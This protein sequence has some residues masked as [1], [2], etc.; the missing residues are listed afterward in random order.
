MQAPLD[1]TRYGRILTVGALVA[2]VVC[3]GV[4]LRLSGSQF[5]QE[6][7]WFPS[8]SDGGAPIAGVGFE[9]A[10][11]T[12][13]TGDGRISAM[14]QRGAYAAGQEVTLTAVAAPGSAFLG[15]AGDLDGVENPITL[16]V[17][18]D[19]EVSATFVADTT[20][21]AISGT[22][23]TP[24][25]T[26]ALIRWTTDDPASS[27]VAVGTTEAHE[28]GTFG[29]SNLTR[30][31]SVT[32]RDLAPGTTYRFAVSSTNGVDMSRRAPEGLFATPASG[33]PA[34]DVFSGP[35][36]VVGA[37]GE[38]QTWVNV[39]GNVGDP[40]GV[41][42]L[43]YSLNGGP[44][45]PLTVGPDQRRLQNPGDFN[46]EI[47]YSDLHPGHNQ[48]VVTATDSGGRVTTSTVDVDRRDGGGP[49]PRYRTDWAGA[50]RIG[51]RAQVVDGRW[52]LDGDTVRPLEP[53]YDRVLAVGDLSWHDY[54]VTVPV[55]VNGIAPTAGSQ[56][57]G[58]ALVGLGL[59]WR[60]HTQVAGEQPGSFWY[61]TGA[62]GWYRW[63]EQNP[64]FELRGNLDTPVI[65][66]RS[67]NLAMGQTYML[68]ARSE[69]V[70]GGV[71]YS[72]KSWPRGTP[73][74]G[75]W[76]LS[77]VEDAGPA[78][79]SVALIAHHVD[80]QFG[81]VSITPIGR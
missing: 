16:T 41:A 39:A 27:R 6:V 52:V 56:N 49:T 19:M 73:E 61:P 15:W 72:W 24:F 44:P 32:V 5:A 57:S 37:H 17:E 65:R 68:K 22:T 38:P 70:A 71:R 43:S 60:G 1:L 21:P 23:V 3:V 55:T 81:D 31:H 77:L 62:L 8:A 74:P 59:H 9:M 64:R 14:P 47:A 20:P 11:S 45:R 34:V 30:D 2:A 10:T 66:A 75:M 35:S 79:G 58:A 25:E 50:T 54:E 67:S 48:V 12:V 18:S 28:L 29:P 36:R 26:S 40:D 7:P 4:G 76:D 69:T 46:A 63:H 53:G 33:G 13:G 78:A 42:S 51:D 80:A